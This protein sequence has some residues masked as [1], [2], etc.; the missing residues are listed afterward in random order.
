VRVSP[1]SAI[2]TRSS[3]SSAQMRT[4]PSA[5]ADASRE[6]SVRAEGDRGD[7]RAELLAQDRDLAARPVADGHQSAD[8]AV[9]TRD[10]TPGGRGG[11]RSGEARPGPTPIHQRTTGAQRARS[12]ALAPIRPR[13]RR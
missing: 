10:A 12:M 9:V 13:C 1:F 6:P 7:A 2:S 5:P 4:V 8:A 3:R 11:L